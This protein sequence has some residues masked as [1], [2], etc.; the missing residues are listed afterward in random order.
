[1]NST[2]KLYR[3]IF[4]KVDINDC[5]MVGVDTDGQ[6]LFYNAE[7]KDVYSNGMTPKQSNDEESTLNNREHIIAYP[8]VYLALAKS[9]L[10]DPA[11]LN[12]V[13]EF[14]LS[15]ARA[16]ADEMLKKLKMD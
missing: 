13:K 3:D 10:F 15:P 14:G 5:D 1:M 11:K 7:E 9:G 2:L 16:A 6:A 4:G 8:L 12:E